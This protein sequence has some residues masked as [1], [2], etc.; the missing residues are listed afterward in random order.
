MRVLGRTINLEQIAFVTQIVVS[1][2]ESGHFSVYFSGGAQ[3]RLEWPPALNARAVA[4]YNALTAAISMRDA[5][6]SL[7]AGRPQPALRPRLNS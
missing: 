1:A 3:V 6:V 2:S 7:H 4:D 5:I